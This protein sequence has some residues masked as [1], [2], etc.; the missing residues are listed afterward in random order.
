MLA[1]TSDDFLQDLLMIVL[2]Q[3]LMILEKIDDAP[4]SANAHID[5]LKYFVSLVK[6]DPSQF[7]SLYKQRVQDE[8]H[9][10]EV[11]EYLLQQLLAAEHDTRELDDVVSMCK[12]FGVEQI[13]EYHGTALKIR[14]MYLTQYM[15]GEHL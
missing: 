8:Q 7:R 10:T 15:L 1:Q 14:K 4:A 9:F 3:A 6:N 2:S 13:S 12:M 5:E 11:I